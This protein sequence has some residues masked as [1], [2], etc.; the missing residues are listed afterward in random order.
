M[1]AL[2]VAYIM[3]I[4]DTHESFFAPFLAPLIC[5]NSF[6]EVLINGEVCP[7]CG[8]PFVFNFV[9]G[10]V[11]NASSR[12]DR[13]TEGPGLNVALNAGGIEKK[14]WGSYALELKGEY[15]VDMSFI[16]LNLFGSRWI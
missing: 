5:I 13:S 12:K 7:L 10:C 6:E 8:A 2:E 11:R 4:G 9:F 16:F 15:F 3:S 14:R 1:S